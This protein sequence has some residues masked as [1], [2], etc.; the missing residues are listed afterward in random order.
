MV[1]VD[2]SN[3]W[4][5]AHFPE[6]L[7]AH[8]A[9]L[10]ATAEKFA[11]WVR[12]NGP[13]PSEEPEAKKPSAIV[14]DIDEVLLCNTH[15]N[16]HGDF[17]VSAFF[18]HADGRPWGRDDEHDPPLPGAAE[19][20]AKAAEAGLAI[21]LVTGRREAI[22]A[23]TVEDLGVFP[24]LEKLEAGPD[25]RLLMSPA[26][27]EGSVQPFKESCRARIAERF[28]IVANVGDQ[29]SDLGKHGER[30]ILMS[31]PFYFTR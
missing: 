9:R 1:F 5:R 13:G 31:H 11:A 29:A 6:W 28:R 10:L 4:L 7:K 23:I 27:P 22:R 14:V 17:H 26:E 19:F 20:V 18:R 2:F 21:F 15:L 16:G 8:R 3:E 24:Q 30:Q 25:T 12:Q